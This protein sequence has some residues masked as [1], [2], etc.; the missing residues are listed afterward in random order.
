[1]FIILLAV[2]VAG[3]PIC[4]LAVLLL[5]NYNGILR[6]DANRSRFGLLFECYT[7]E[8]Y[9]WQFVIFVRRVVLVVLCNSAAYLDRQNS[10]I[11]ASFFNIIWLGLQTFFR[12]Y[13]NLLDNILESMQ[14]AALSLI[15]VQ[16][17]DLPLQFNVSESI[18]MGL[19]TFGPF[20]ILL[21]YLFFNR[22][23]PMALRVHKLGN[24]LKSRQ[25]VSKNQ[26][27]KGDEDDTGIEMAGMSPAF[28]PRPSGIG[29]VRQPAE[30][31]FANGA[32]A[33]E[34]Q[35]E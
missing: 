23:A 21:F 19:L 2:V 18:G 13:R 11:W 27:S 30:E 7:K 24:W 9:Y 26:L 28:T 22:W 1:L 12:P 5:N 15:S 16:L 4:I 6:S 29:D 3:G 8:N 25:L 17:I 31:T 35:T 34:S 10:L 33:E 14:L 20:I 32:T